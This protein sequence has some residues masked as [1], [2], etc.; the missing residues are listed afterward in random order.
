MII[1][2]ERLGVGV[3]ERGDGVVERRV[4]EAGLEPPAGAAPV[5]QQV[6]LVDRRRRGVV[7]LG[8]VLVE[9]VDE[10]GAPGVQ[11]GGGVLSGVGGELR[12]RA[13]PYLGREP[14]RGGSGEHLR[15]DL[16]MAQPGVAGVEHLGGGRQLWGQRA[17][18]EADT[19]AHPGGGADPAAG[20]EPLPAQ[21]IA[22]RRCGGL[23]AAFGE[24]AA[25][26]QVGDGGD[27]ELVEAAGE[28]FA[29]GEDGDQ[30]VVGGGG[31][32]GSAQLLDRLDEAVVRCGKGAGHAPIVSEQVFE[33]TLIH[34]VGRL[35]SNGRAGRRGA[36][37]RTSGCAIRR[38]RNPRKART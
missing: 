12:F 27:G 29:E 13:R 16:D 28:P 30:L 25:S 33:V 21:Q 11:L 23:V 24:S 15:D 31:P 8:A 20:F 6:Q 9:R 19:G 35:F 1:G 4:V 18:V 36:G 32:A 10:R 37:D 26:L 22:E 5:G 14:H 2:I 38:G 3:D 34:T 7:G 17:A